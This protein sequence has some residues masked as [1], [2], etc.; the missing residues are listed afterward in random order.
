MIVIKL[1]SPFSSLIKIIS[2][3]LIK[4]IFSKLTLDE[5]PVFNRVDL[6]QYLEEHNEIAKKSTQ[7]IDT[8]VE[9]LQIKV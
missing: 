2:N 4:L 7:G 5:K 9:I 8:E 3:F 6:D 1:L